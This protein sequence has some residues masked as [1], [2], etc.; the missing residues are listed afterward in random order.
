MNLKQWFT[1]YRMNRK[2]KSLSDN[3]KALVKM[4][5]MTPEDYKNQFRAKG[6]A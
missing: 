6:E 1:Y 4:I 2:Y 5:K 3:G